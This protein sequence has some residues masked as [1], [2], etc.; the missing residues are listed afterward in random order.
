MFEQSKV[1]RGDTTL[2]QDEEF[3]RFVFWAISPWLMDRVLKMRYERFNE[4]LKRRVKGMKEGWKLSESRWS[5][6]VMLRKEALK[7]WSLVI[8]LYRLSKSACF[9]AMFLNLQKQP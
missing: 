3:G 5:R 2:A 7:C 1:T 4:D 9:K 6:H 8:S